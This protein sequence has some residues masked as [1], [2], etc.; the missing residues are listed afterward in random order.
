MN[1][2]LQLN[3]ALP[4]EHALSDVAG[5]LPDFNHN[6]DS[7]QL[8]PHPLVARQ[9]NSDLYLK[10]CHLSFTEETPKWCDYGNPEAKKL[11]VLIGDSHAAAL[12]P[13]LEALVTA[14]RDYKLRVTTKSACGFTNTLI[15]ERGK[16]YT[17]CANRNK[18]ALPQILAWKPY[19]VVTTQSKGQNAYKNKSPEENIQLLTQG[20][21]SLW[22]TLHSNNIKV[23]AV[24][25]TPRHA[26]DIPTCLTIASNSILDCATQKSSAIRRKEIIKTAANLSGAIYLD[27]T[28]VFCDEKFCFP[29]RGN[30]LMWRDEHHITATF[31]RM[32]AKYF[33]EAL[34]LD[35]QPTVKNTPSTETKFVGHLSCSALKGGEKF[36]TARAVNYHQGTLTFYRGEYHTFF[37]QTAE[38]LTI[39]KKL[40]ISG[41]EVWHGVT[42][43]NGEVTVIGWYAEGGP[44]TKW[45][46]LQ[47]KVK[48]N[49]LVLKGKRGPRQCEFTGTLLAPNQI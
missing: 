3:Q 9:D 39:A 28:D 31:S 37:K 14:N 43:D 20:L 23:L 38:Q 36:I 40:P 48:D 33:A 27:L 8:V 1:I 25:D 7:N 44:E 46:V 6:I 49:Q 11:I 29:N 41:I 45:V 18:K 42:R 32:L 30:V 16:P 22:T 4:Q 2:N 21:A 10:G 5:Q 13:A 35:Y 15:R 19:V 12:M 34:A 24:A 17:K 47:G 26:K